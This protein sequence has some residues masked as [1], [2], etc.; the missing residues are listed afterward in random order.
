MWMVWLVWSGPKSHGTPRT[1]ASK[2]ITRVRSRI[3]VGAISA[4]R[5]VPSKPVSWQKRLYRGTAAKAA[6]VMPNTTTALMSAVRRLD[7]RMRSASEMGAD[8]DI[9]PPL[10][11]GDN[12]D[13]DHER[14][15]P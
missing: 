2:R 8:D 10:H 4:L 9:A 14:H 13:Q 3:W 7:R 11:D 12:E 15:Q 1:L 5:T 6:P